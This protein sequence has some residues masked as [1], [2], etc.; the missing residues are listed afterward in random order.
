LKSDV[1]RAFDPTNPR[2]GEI[3]LADPVKRS[4]QACSRIT[5]CETEILSISSACLA[6][7]T[8]LMHPPTSSVQA[9]EIL[10][11]HL[12]L[13]VRRSAFPCPPS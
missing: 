1:G 6:A 10:A 4:D 3:F 9:S 11:C 5:N 8:N 7:D 13:R 2:P 12:N